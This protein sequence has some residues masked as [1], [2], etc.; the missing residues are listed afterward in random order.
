V[1]V[2]AVGIVIGDHDH[3]MRPIV[4]ALLQK[5]DHLNDEGLLVERIGVAGVAVLIG[6]SLQKAYCREV[7]GADGSKEIEDVV[8][9]IGRACVGLAV[10]G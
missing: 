6:R 3:R 9:M 4:A 1:I 8:L 2:P 5:V 7:S 10:D